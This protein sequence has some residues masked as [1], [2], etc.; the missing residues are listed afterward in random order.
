MEHEDRGAGKGRG[1]GSACA[2]PGGARAWGVGAPRL[3]CEPAIP[4]EP[5]VP[6]EPA[7]P[8]EPAVAPE[9]TEVEMPRTEGGR[10]SREALG[11][12]GR[13]P[14]G[15]GALRPLQF[16]FRNLQIRIL[17]FF[18]KVT[19]GLDLR[20]AR[21]SETG[22]VP[23]RASEVSDRGRNRSAE[24]SG[25]RRAADRRGLVTD[26][27]SQRPLWA[28]PR[29]PFPQ[30]RDR[31]GLR[32][33][34]LSQHRLPATA[35]T[36]A[37]RRAPGRSPA[38]VPFPMQRVESSRRQGRHSSRAAGIPVP[39]SGVWGAGGPGAPT[40]AAG[41][42]ASSHWLFRGAASGLI[43]PGGF[44]AVGS[45]R[46]LGADAAS[47]SGHRCVHPA[48]VAE[49]VQWSAWGPRQTARCPATRRQGAA[50]P[51]APLAV[52]AEPRFC[53]PGNRSNKKRFLKFCM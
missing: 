16:C 10:S 38:W 3:R 26:G 25:S 41:C 13:G 1:P 6:A 19:T 37:G 8:A 18:R 45:R 42:G 39:A 34:A 24:T 49:H 48:G 51:M 23:R 28:S 29:R 43:S 53:C 33:R 36:G 11:R 7:M 17:S 32:T 15:S 5:A 21:V 46:T 47:G 2:D 35:P 22:V 52:T 30:P 50:R 31:G 12:R 27:G 40:R 9:A 14:F 4:A 44:L 20:L